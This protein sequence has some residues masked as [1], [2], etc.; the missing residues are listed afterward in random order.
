M[1]L[2]SCLGFVGMMMRMHDDENKKNDMKCANQ[3]GMSVAFHE[4]DVLSKMTSNQIHWQWY[5]VTHSRIKKE[6]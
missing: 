6:K 2:Q 4:W 5:K 3:V 1:M